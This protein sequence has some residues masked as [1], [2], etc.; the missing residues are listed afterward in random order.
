MLPPYDPIIKKFLLILDWFIVNPLTGIT[1]P[2]FFLNIKNPLIGYFK[3]ILDLRATDYYP[4]AWFWTYHNNIFPSV[5][6]ERI[7]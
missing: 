5:P 1:S 3:S 6:K 2:Y 7:L 4:M